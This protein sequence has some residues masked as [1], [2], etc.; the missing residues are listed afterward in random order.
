MTSIRLAVPCG[1]GPNPLLARMTRVQKG[2]II[3]ISS[4]RIRT[5]ESL[6]DT[7]RRARRSISGNLE[8]TLSTILVT[9]RVEISPQTETGR[10]WPPPRQEM[11]ISSSVSLT[12]RRISG[13]PRCTRSNQAEAQ[14]G[15]PDH[16][17]SLKIIAINCL[18]IEPR[19]PCRIS[20]SCTQRLAALL[21][22][23]RVWFPLYLDQ[24]RR[25][26]PVGVQIL[27]SY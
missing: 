27:R 13:D 3:T 9:R 12:R 7:D 21:P 17:D 19:R 15:C 14:T 4:A 11:V 16:F 20:T 26:G 1:S 2:Q 18:G 22:I 24:A 10:S 25:E 6:T 5:R 8:G 23:L